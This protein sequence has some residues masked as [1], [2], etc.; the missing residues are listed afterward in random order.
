MTEEIF[1]NKS[2]IRLVIFI[3]LAM[4][5]FYIFSNWYSVSPDG[6][7]LPLKGAGYMLGF[8]GLILLGG[9]LGLPVGL[10]ATLLRVKNKNFPGPKTWS[11][12]KLLAILC[13]IFI[14]FIVLAVR[15]GDD[16]RNLGLS[17]MAAHGKPL[18][19]AI[20]HYEAVNKSSPDALNNLVPA[21]VVNIPPTGAAAHPQ[22][23]FI[24]NQNPA[25]FSGNPWVL[26]VPVSA[27]KSACEFLVYYPNQK[28]PE[29]RHGNV[30]LTKL[31]SW[32]LIELNTSEA[33]NEGFAT[34]SDIND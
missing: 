32:V 22:F 4:C 2:R 17:R 25:L 26:S 14:L 23:N 9:L 15:I 29:W 19:E 6:S 31:G 11:D 13:L 21:Y 5:S 7:D 1:S 28:Y 3:S 34:A 10:I 24:R 27:D 16:V 12:L 33:T 18:I 30:D 20:Q 8:W